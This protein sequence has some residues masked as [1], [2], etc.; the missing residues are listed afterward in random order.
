MEVSSGN[1]SR[2]L[3]PIT[4]WGLGVGYVISGM[5][6][7]WNLGLPAGGTLG[8]AIALF[9]ISTMYVAFTFSYC[10]LACAIPKAGGAFDYVTLAMGPSW[11]FVAGMAQL[12]EFIFAPPAIAAGIGAY[13]ALFF[14][15]IN[16][17]FIAI[18]AYCL[19][20]GFNIYGVKAAASFELMITLI[21]VIELLIFIGFTLPHF[22]YHHFMHNPLPNGVTGI[23]VALPFAIWF[24]LG[25]EGVA[26]M[27][28][29]TVNPQRNILLGFGSAMLT[30]VLLSIL[31][32]LSATGIG[33]WEKIVYPVA[34]ATASNSPLPLAL[35]QL[36]S[37]QHLLFKMLVM[38]GLLGLIASFHGLILAGGRASF[39]FG[40][41][42]FAPKRLGRLHQKFHT[43][44]W[45]LFINMLIGIAALLTGKTS[46]LITLSC[47]G[48]LCLYL[49]SMTAV[50]KLRRSHPTLFRPFRVPF[51]PY[52]PLIAFS[53][54]ACALIVMSIYNS[55]LA[56]VYFIFLAIAL[57]GFKLFVKEKGRTDALT[58]ETQI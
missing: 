11:G 30:I 17:L 9:F 27:A 26:N 55:S 41:V 53:I 28:E 25:I 10:E 19:F 38:I 16:P 39:E 47:F 24:F 34:H 22:Q 3:G 36:V 20:T 32:F 51:Y 44:A 40:R 5:Y 8:L 57:C 13:C 45:A 12:I 37:E 46:E 14:P 1:F 2:S 18:V 33:G 50:I 43:P 54:A 15:S 7:G 6:F 35:N 48:A 42:G 4:L 31:T 56:W 29:E 58:C 49:I 52:A 23:F 21:A